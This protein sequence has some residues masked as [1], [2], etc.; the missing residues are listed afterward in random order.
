M[1]RKPLI[2]QTAIV[3]YSSLLLSACGGSS[4]SDAYHPPLDDSGQYYV[5]SSASLNSDGAGGVETY[6]LIESI[7]GQG[8]IEAPDLYGDANHDTIKHI[9][10][11]HDSMVGNYFRF[12]IHRD[13][14]KDRDKDYTDRQRNEIKVYDKSVDSLKGFKDKTFEYRWKFRVGETLAVTNH[15]NHLF[16]LKAVTDN[17]DPV[18]QPLVTITANTKSGVSGLEVR[19]VDS[20]DNKTMLLHTSQQNIDW[21]T[22][23]QGQWLEVLVRTTYSETGA[24][25]LSVTPVGEQSPLF[26]IS[27]D[28]LEMWRS[29]AN[30]SQGNFVRP[31]WG[32]YRSLKDKD[33]LNEEEDEVWFADFSIKEVEKISE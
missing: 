12:V 18:S 29:G 14:D 30:S 15:F 11:D 27:Q 4:P 16:Q 3:I 28:N 6:Q 32:I 26:A 2:I 13:H 19:H 23:I 10:E 7:L 5:I 24:L 33:A 1:S 25:Y 20:A 8:S 22:Q 31:K 9:T 17:G 21:A